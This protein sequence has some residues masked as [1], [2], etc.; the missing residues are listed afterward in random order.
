MLAGFL[1]SQ[2]FFVLVGWLGCRCAVLCCACSAGP[3]LPLLPLHIESV[4]VGAELA[5]RLPA[6][7]F[8]ACTNL[9]IQVLSLQTISSQIMPTRPP[10]N[11]LCSN[12]P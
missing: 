7:T 1:C 11:F 6:A 5:L 9:I 3:P 8:S 12:T 2:G 4:A 10:T